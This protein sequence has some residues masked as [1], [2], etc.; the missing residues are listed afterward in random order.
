M[1]RKSIESRDNWEKKV[2][3]VGLLFHHTPEGLYWD[4]TA[5]YRFTARQVDELERATNELHALCLEAVQHIIDEDR[6]ADLAIPPA[7]VPL[8]RQA[9]E[10]EPPSLYGRFD[11]SYDGKSPPKLLEYNADTPTSLL[12]ASVV[13]WFWLEERFRGADQFNSIHERLIAKWTELKDYISAYPLYFTC[14]GG[15]V[16]DATTVGYL[17][18]TA[19]QAGIPTAWILVEDIGWDDGLRQFVDLQDGR[20]TSLFK[21]YPWEW[22]LSD[23]FGPCLLEAYREMQW[24]EPMWKLILSNKGILPILWELYPGHPNLLETYF[25]GPRH[26]TDF[27]RKPLYSREGAN[28]LIQRADGGRIESGGSYGAEGHIYQ[29][30]ALLPEFDGNFPLIGSWVIDGESAGIGIRETRTPVTDNYSRF[31]PHLLD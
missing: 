20:I 16:E 21:L 7:A 9:W 4:E 12:E 22:L 15:S 11:F 30:L 5:Y 27:V 8:I 19:Q 10:D 18:D 28:V 17:Q 2:E 29:R 23:E 3:E 25:E 24:I 26:L 31:I 1:K 6:F 14:G 13:Q